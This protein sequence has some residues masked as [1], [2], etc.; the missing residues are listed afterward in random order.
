MHLKSSSK[1]AGAAPA[2]FELLFKVIG[3]KLKFSAYFPAGQTEI[4]DSVRSS[5]LLLTLTPT[6]PPATD[7]FDLQQDRAWKKVITF[8]SIAIEIGAIK[9][10][11]SRGVLESQ[12]ACR[13]GWGKTVTQLP[14]F[15]NTRIT[16][17]RADGAQLGSC[18]TRGCVRLLFAFYTG[19]SDLG[20]HRISILRRHITFFV[21]PF[22]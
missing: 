19:S 8:V 18:S 12:G 16:G 15:C 6:Q 21:C 9:I 13:R 4:S 14:L 10:S 7:P 5:C 20:F 22:T 2:S 1:D 17:I 11:S 3:Q